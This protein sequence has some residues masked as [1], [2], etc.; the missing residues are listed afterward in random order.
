MKR[1]IKIRI[2]KE[3]PKDILSEYFSPCDIVDTTTTLEIKNK[4]KEGIKFPYE[5]VKESFYF[6]NKELKDNEI[7]G[8]DGDLSYKLIVK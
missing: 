8:E 3:S 7:I 6:K 5:I 1:P 2:E 4:I